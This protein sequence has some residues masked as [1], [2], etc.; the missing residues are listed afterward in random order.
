[1]TP[2]QVASIHAL[3][4]NIERVFYGKPEAVKALLVAV[5]SSGHVLIEDVPGIG[6]TLLAK[7]LARSLAC[8]EF[9]YNS[10]IPIF[11]MHGASL[12]L[13]IENKILDLVRKAGGRISKRTLQQSLPRVDAKT[14]N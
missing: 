9:L 6:K 8:M 1:M 2:E 5:F 3:Q 12:V 4:K 10:R 7:A 11:A 14:F 13:E